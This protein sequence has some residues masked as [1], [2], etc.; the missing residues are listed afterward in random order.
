M[1]F[2]N[3]PNTASFGNTQGSFNNTQ[4]NFGN[5]QSTTN[6][7]PKPWEFRGNIVGN[8]VKDLGEIGAAIT[9][10]PGIVLGYDKEA[11]KAFLETAKDPKKFINNMLSSYNVEIDD[12]GKVGFG[13]FVGNIAAGVWEHPLQVALDIIPIASAAKVKVPKVIKDKFPKL[14]DWEVRGKLGEE[15][16]RENIQVGN[17]AREFTNQ[18]D[19]IYK[20][21][22]QKT[23]SQ[24]MRGIEEY[25][26]KR[27]KP[28]LKSV[29]NELLRANDTY[30]QMVELAG[31]KIYDDADFATLELMSKRTK[32]PFSNFDNK[33]FRKTKQYYN[34]LE[35]VTANGIKPLFHLRPML[36]NYNSKT[37]DLGIE[38]SLL[39]RQFG[40]Q[41]YTRAAKDLDKKARDFTEKLLQT[42]IVDSPERINKKIKRYNKVNEKNV[43]ELDTSRSPF[44]SQVLNELNSELK[45]VMLSGG[46]YLGANILST[47]LS[48]LNNW[49]TNAIKQ[50]ITNLPRF[51]KATL[52]EAETPGLKW[53]SKFNNV[54]YRPIASVDRWL[55][56]VGRIYQSNLPLEKQ[57]FSQSIVSSAITPSNIVEE[58]ISKFVPFGSYPIAAGREVAANVV[59]R[60]YRTLIYNQLGKEFSQINQLAQENTP[61]INE[62]DPT[63]VVRYNPE[64]QKLIQRSTVITPIQAMNMFLL[65]TSG[66]AI[67]VPLYQFINKMV[68]GSGDPHVFTVNGKNYRINTDGTIETTQGNFNIIPALRYATRNMLSPV[69]FY[70]QVL[71]P[72]TTDKYIYDTNAVTNHI[73]TNAQYS[74]MSNQARNKVTTN[75]RAKLG[76]R[77][78]G[79]YEYNYYKPYV[80]RRTRQSIMRQ[81]RTRE[82]IYNRWKKD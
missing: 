23:I 66:D 6:D 63:K 28:E 71:V 76:K 8:V 3:L 27:M 13:D 18:I 26:F 75:A 62:V 70:N 58:L 56:D 55:E 52:L 17:L 59:G 37:R 38:T 35:E 73:V 1:S 43:K 24:A 47:T 44:N 9:T 10:L 22:D 20:K 77:V 68:E 4:T 46:T 33:R 53:I 7:R 32:Q 65:G 72:L 79:T 69:Q 25:G 42:V 41:N 80:N 34:T 50:T 19:D 31:A 39:E 12:I 82:E 45:K 30:K 51:R 48:I 64:E 2:N 16:T 67:Q 36:K 11:Q 60:P 78:V 14:E 40:T 57:K 21:Y 49:D 54:F 15:V 5:Q 61:E 81:Q 74:N 29:A